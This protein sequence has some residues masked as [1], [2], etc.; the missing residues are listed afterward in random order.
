VTPAVFIAAALGC[1]VG[2]VLRFALS[3][4]R[5][6]HHAPWPTMVANLLGTV[7]LGAAGALLDHGTLS[8]SAAFIVGGG[9]AGGLTTFSTLA[10][11]AVVWW[12]TSRRGAVLYVVATGVFGVAAGA[13]GWVIASALTA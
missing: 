11:D 10:V 13:L 9:V 12:R 5:R 1:G 2:A 4:L 7:L 6:E 3:T 8:S